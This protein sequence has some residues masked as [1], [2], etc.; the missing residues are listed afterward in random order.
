MLPSLRDVLA[1]DCLCNSSSH[2]AKAES[3]WRVSLAAVEHLLK[4]LIG[5][6]SNQISQGLVL[7]A[8]TPVFSQPEITQN[9]DVLTFTTKPFNPLALM[10]FNISAFDNKE[11]RESI[12]SEPVLPLI[13]A[14][15]IASEQFCL[16]FTERFRLA[17]VLAEDEAGEKTFLFSF[18]SEIVLQAWRSLGARIILNNRDLFTS[19]EELVQ[20]YNPKETDCTILMQFSQM[21]LQNLPFCDEETGVHIK[22]DKKADK[23]L[24]KTEQVGIN[25]DNFTC[26]NTPDTSVSNN[27][28][29]HDVEF[30]QAFAHEVRTPLTTIRTMTRLLLKQKNLPDSAIRRLEIIDRECTEQID[31]ME[32]L[33]RAVELETSVSNNSSPA[34]QL[35]PMCLEQI[36]QHSIPRWQQAANR[37]NLTLDVVLPQQVPMVISNPNM[38]DRVLT[39]VIENFTRS[40]P[41]GSEIQVQVIP[42]GNQLKL[43]LLTQMQQDGST[44]VPSSCNPPIRK[45]IGELLTFQPETGVVSLNLA[46]TKH[47]FQAIGGKLIVRQRP[48]QG[49]VLTIF[50]PLEGMRETK[51]TLNKIEGNWCQGNNLN[52]LKADKFRGGVQ[53]I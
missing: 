22:A 28:S 18:G 32:L 7:T 14:D 23:K 27:S 1:K 52:R 13:G 4:N 30:L 35:T 50:L 8:P 17:L 37:R 29:C 5:N 36:L 53:S 3:Q 45:A 41:A 2:S 40:L 46:A 19:I 26:E 6:E 48:H 47:L 12:I 51:N 44:K 49:E 43:Q 34:T 16:I 10:P 9:L 39:G 31:R 15:A 25:I 21:L 33:F 24:G 11:Q 38:L 42:A 20:Q